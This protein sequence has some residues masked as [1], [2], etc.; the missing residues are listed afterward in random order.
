MNQ[1]EI[2]E[3]IQKLRKD[4]KKRQFNQTFDFVMN[5]KGLDLKNP[6]HNINTF[7][8]L[9]HS[10]GR[11]NKIGV[12]VGKE[13]GGKV[14]DEC[15]EVIHD[16]DLVALAKDKKKVKKLARHVDFFMAQ[17]NIMPK[18]A[19]SLGRVLGPMGK[20]PS[21]KAGCIVPP[22]IPSL[23]P[24]ADK[25]RNTVKLQTKNE[26]GIKVSVGKE[27]MKD[28]EIAENILAIYNHIIHLLPQE[29]QNVKNAFVKLTMGK[30]FFIGKKKVVETVEEEVKGKPKKE[31]KVEKKPKEKKKVEKPK[32]KKVKK[33][34]A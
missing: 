26:P 7:L 8:Q 20:M 34:G 33:D 24:L 9:P 23:K 12:I 21:P 14:K 11:Q 10:K 32:V 18:I 15:D 27:D 4:S 28:E 31:V 6:E 22:T 16:K 30:S 13:L 1:K 2:L 29:T 3:A 19:T 25:L 17:A 5:F